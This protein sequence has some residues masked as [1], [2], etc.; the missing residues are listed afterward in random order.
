MGFCG[1]VFLPKYSDSKSTQRLR[2]EFAI[3]LRRPQRA[4]RKR[5]TRLHSDSDR[6][7]GRLTSVQ[8]AARAFNRNVLSSRRRPRPS[9]PAIY[10]ALYLC[11][12]GRCD[13]ARTDP[14]RRARVVG[15]E[16]GS[17]NA[18]PAIRLMGFRS[19]RPGALRELSVDGSI[20]AAAARSGRLRL[21]IGPE[22]DERVLDFE[23][24]SSAK[25][26][27]RRTQPMERLWYESDRANSRATVVR[28]PGNA[29]AN[30]RAVVRDVARGS[31]AISP[32][33]Q[34]L[35]ALPHS[36]LKAVTAS[37]TP[38]STA[39]V[40]APVLDSQHSR[41]QLRLRIRLWRRTC[42]SSSHGRQVKYDSCLGPIIQ[43]CVP[44]SRGH[45]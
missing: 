17:E 19:S 20:G 27:R 26:W 45:Y 23:R 15:V 41:H 36:S 12:G 22:L 40:S 14:E 11:C 3:G 42:A 31:R 35:S 4:L 30:Q 32:P 25:I 2:G 8:D 43:N 5:E 33:R 10:T 7:A 29:L 16:Q 44:C 1:S 9:S 13:T 24:R 37:E 34:C 28:S 38:A 18:T 6:V 21:R 39:I